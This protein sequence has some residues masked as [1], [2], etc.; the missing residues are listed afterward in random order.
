[1]TSQT[2]PRMENRPSLESLEWRE[3]PVSTPVPGPVSQESLAR[4]NERESN[5]RSYPR[6]LPI[7]VRRAEGTLVEDVDGNVYLDFLSG[8]GV[9][10]LGHNHPEIVAAVT[11]QLS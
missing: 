4:Q 3:P 10:S 11:A 9:L 1:M 2:L 5:A 8:A 6:R 7:A